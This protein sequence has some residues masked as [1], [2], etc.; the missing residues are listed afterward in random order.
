MGWP[1]HYWTYLDE[2]LNG[3]LR[4]LAKYCHRRTFH[5]RVH[6]MFD[7]LGTLSAQG[8]VAAGTAVA[9]WQTLVQG[10]DA[11]SWRRSRR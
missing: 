2:G 8:Y 7:L 4:T 1:R 6:K 5:E 9:T 3:R 11:F 10:W